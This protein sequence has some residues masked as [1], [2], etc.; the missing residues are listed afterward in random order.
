MRPHEIRNRARA[1]AAHDRDAAARTLAAWAQQLLADPATTCF[2]WR[3]Y[4]AA[5]AELGDRETARDYLAHAHATTGEELCD[6]AGGYRALGDLPTA[7]ALVARAEALGA[8]SHVACAYELGDRDPASA[9][10]RAQGGRAR[11]LA[12]GGR[13][14]ET[15]TGSSG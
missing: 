15:R 5:W 7:A 14:R 9:V 4:A 10:R 2:T 8:W 12:R 6:L 3:L 1:E 11:A 13:G